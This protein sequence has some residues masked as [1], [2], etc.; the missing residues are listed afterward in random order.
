[1]SDPGMTLKRFEFRGGLCAPRTAAARSDARLVLQDGA[2]V[3]GPGRLGAYGGTG[4]GMACTRRSKSSV[5]TC[6][7]LSGITNIACLL[8]VGWVTNY[9]SHV[10]SPAAPGT[11][12]EEDGSSRAETLRIMER[13]ERLESV[14]KQH[15]HGTYM[16]III[17]RTYYHDDIQFKRYGVSSVRVVGSAKDRY[18]C[19]YFHRLSTKNRRGLGNI[20]ERARKGVLAP[21][22]VRLFLCDSPAGCAQEERPRAAPRNSSG[23]IEKLQRSRRFSPPARGFGGSVA[24]APPIDPIRSERPRGALF[25]ERPRDW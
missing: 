21:G 10:W 18:V 16:M 12:L 13:L 23:D 25:K 3:G 1:M 6:V 5:W 19:P 14:V 15:I 24:V 7:V 22:L 20:E 9:L 11:R 8:Y 2:R 17:T 4:V